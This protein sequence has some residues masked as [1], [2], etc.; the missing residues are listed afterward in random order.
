MWAMT[1]NSSTNSLSL[2]IVCVQ[3]FLF[4]V[5]GA[6]YKL[7]V[8]PTWFIC[9]EDL[10]TCVAHFYVGMICSN[11]LVFPYC[12]YLRSVKQSTQSI[13]PSWQL[14]KIKAWL[15][16]KHCINK[17]NIVLLLWRQIAKLFKFKLSG[18]DYDPGNYAAV[19]QTFMELVETW[20][21]RTNIWILNFAH[22]HNV[23]P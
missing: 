15:N 9:S 20:K 10:F 22:T 4:T 2:F 23:R 17:M 14:V 5:Y 7:C 18:C 11:T 6:E 12:L 1:S 13:D 19:W 21:E 8:R 3:S 16:T